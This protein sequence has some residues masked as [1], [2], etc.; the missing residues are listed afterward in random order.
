MAAEFLIAGSAA[1]QKNR[2][3]KIPTWLLGP[4]AMLR[5]ASLK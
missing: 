3:S 4:H 1:R 5:F 2:A